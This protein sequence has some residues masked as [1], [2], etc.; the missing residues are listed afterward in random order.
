MFDFD[1]D[2][3]LLLLNPRMPRDERERLERLFAAAPPLRSHV[4]LATSG[5]T[6]ALKLTALSKSAILTSAAAVNRHLAARADDV[7]ACVLPEF[8]VGGLGIYARAFLAGNRVVRGM[9]NARDFAKMEGVTLA[10]LVPA[11]VEDLVRSGLRAPERLRA[12]IVGGG[13]LSEDLY[14]AARALGWPLL[15]SYGMTECA[16]QVATAELGSPELILLDHLE[17][18]VDD[19]RLTVR[20]A[21]LFTGYAT[22]AG[23]VDPKIEGWFATEDFGRVEGR[24]LHIAGR[25]GDFVKIGGESVDLLRLDAILGSIAGPHAAV[26]AVPDER[27]GHVV[28]LVGDGEPDMEAVRVAYDARVHP[29]ERA[30]AVHRVSKIP[31]TAL[32]KLMRLRLAEMIPNLLE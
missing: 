17:I 1:D 25:R 23:F 7:W 13:A 20:G 4:W 10:S 18:R 19:G 9:W 26:V 11:Q 28:H 16:S 24:T 27:L 6:G 29:F 3:S 5:T 12:I 31:R 22:A 14:R 8:H 32:G 30:R 21:S 15:P 2:K